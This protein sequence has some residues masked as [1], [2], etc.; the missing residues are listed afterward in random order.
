MGFPLKSSPT[1]EIDSKS[2]ELP[3]KFHLALKVSSLQFPVVSTL[4]GGK[5]VVFFA[6]SPYSFGNSQPQHCS[7]ENTAEADDGC[8]ILLE[9]SEDDPFFDKKMVRESIEHVLT[10]SLSLSRYSDLNAFL[11]YRSS[12]SSRLLN[13][14]GFG[15]KEIVHIKGTLDPNSLSSLLHRM[16]QIARIIH[17]DEVELYFGQI[18]GAG[19]YSPRNEMEALNS[20][21]SF[22]R[23]SFS[24]QLHSQTHALQDLRDAVVNMIHEFGTKN[25]VED[26]TDKNYNC[27]KEQCLVEWAKDHG[28]KT[29][30]QIAYIEGAGRGAITMENLEVGDIAM[31]IP[32]SIIIS[33]DLVYKSDMYHILEKI[34]EMSS[35]TMLLLWSMKEKHNCNSQFKM[36]FDTLPENFNTGLSFGVEAIMVLDGTLLFE[37][38]MQAKEHLRAQ[39]NE[40]FPALSNDHPDIFPPELYTWEHFLWACELWYSNSMKIMFADGKLRTCLIPVAGFLNHSLHPHIVRYGKVDLATNSLKFPLSRPCSVGEQCCLSYGNLSGSHLITFYGFLP[41]GDNPYDIIPLEFDVDQVDSMEECPL[42]NWTTHMSQP[43]LEVEKEVLE[44]LQSTFNGMMENLGDTDSVDRE[45]ASW[46]VKL[47]LEYK[48]IQR[49][50]VSLI[51]TSCS[52]AADPY[53]I[54]TL[55]W[56]VIMVIAASGGA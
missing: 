30:L 49:R 46:E 41:Q 25:K 18:D 53:N 13:D 34:D 14:K 20:I 29:R 45:N 15:I 55:K 31:E 4:Y 21:L 52:T 27:D 28:V 36:Y 39:Y 51:L 5:Q 9:L 7:C 19:S 32:A 42:S 2:L 56:L 16:L 23:T 3:P 43:N 33:E 26:K 22:I 12:L 17:L 48:E 37:E 35:E 38:L 1:T 54:I 6:M 47:A 44:D 24:S 40:L 10:L 11:R 50:I 8:S